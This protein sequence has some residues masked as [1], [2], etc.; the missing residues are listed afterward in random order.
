[1]LDTEFNEE[2][3]WKMFQNDVDAEKKRA[4]EAEARANDAEAKLRD[5]LAEIARLKAVSK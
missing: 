4:D 3:V 2:E 5:A 1:M